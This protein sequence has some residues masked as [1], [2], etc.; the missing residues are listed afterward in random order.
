TLAIYMY[1]AGMKN[2][3]L[4]QGTAIGMLLLVVGAVCSVI[5]TKLMKTD[6]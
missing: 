1:N 5:Y 2:F 6:D 4:G 3:Q